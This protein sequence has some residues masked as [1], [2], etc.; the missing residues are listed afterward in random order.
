YM[1]WQFEEMRINLGVDDPYLTSGPTFAFLSAGMVDSARLFL[2]SAPQQVGSAAVVLRAHGMLC[3]TVGEMDCARHYYTIA[4]SSTLIET[5][6]RAAE[7]L[8]ADLARVNK[9]LGN[10]WEAI[11]F[12]DLAIRLNPDSPS[13][14]YQ[15]AQLYSQVGEIEKAR[16]TLEDGLDLHPDN[17]KLRDALDELI[18]TDQ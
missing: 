17:D 15:L 1:L 14:W 13:Y 18:G 11:S 16:R 5:E 7:E 4:L 3:E 10:T 2:N 9:A 8:A 12:M 6:P